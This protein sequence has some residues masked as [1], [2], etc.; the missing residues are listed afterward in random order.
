M[1]ASVL[2]LAPTRRFRA[3]SGAFCPLL[4]AALALIASPS[5]ASVTV[6][7]W[8]APTTETFDHNNPPSDLP[9]GENGDATA[10]VNWTSTPFNG[11]WNPNTNEYTVTDEGAITITGHTKIR[12]PDN[13]NA[14]LTAHEN[15][16]DRLSKSEYDRLAKKKVEDAMKG[17]VGQKF[18]GVGAT[19]AAR[20][21]D[22]K[23]KA[24]A[25]RDK[26]MKRA[27]DSILQ[28]MDVLNNKYDDLT[29]HG[30][31]GT[32]DTP[33]GETKAKEEQAKAPPAG[34]A[35]VPADGSKPSEKSHSMRT[36]YDPDRQTLVCS[37]LGPID[38]TSSVSDPIRNRG[39]VVIDSLIHVG[40][41]VN[42]TIRLADARV[43]IIDIQNGDTLMNAY[44]LEPA[45]MPPNQP[46][47]AAM[48]QGYLDV[49][50]TYA[51]GIRN[52]I[53]SPFLAG[54]ETASALGWPTTVWIFTSQPLFDA[55]GNPSVPPTGV[56][57][58]TMI[59][60]GLPAAGVPAM[61]PWSVAAGLGLLLVAGAAALRRRRDAA[62]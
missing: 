48:I 28:Q 57:T 46:G 40:T 62:H 51:G 13:A 23:A 44:L 12:L 52:T 53:N 42:G 6:S 50:P 41:Q 34:N 33:T 8:G 14:A 5:R 10:D 59:G 22:A 4:L 27:T 2:A 47:Y 38:E 15:G 32:V 3:R 60:V 49:P 20:L 24:T 1:I 54:M 35:P 43:Q 19:D 18:T 7:T 61:P 11:T 26:R 9:A 45:Y 31:S 56:P 16:H 29:K 17:F 37:S 58:T 25:E 39:I 36:Q 55:S 30:S 21:A